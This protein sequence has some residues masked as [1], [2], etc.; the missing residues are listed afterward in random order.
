[1]PSNL[2]PRAGLDTSLMVPVLPLVI[3]SC[4]FPDFTFTRSPA[5]KIL[6]LAKTNLQLSEFHGIAAILAAQASF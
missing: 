1:M 2:I 3:G 6:S 4:S 5:L